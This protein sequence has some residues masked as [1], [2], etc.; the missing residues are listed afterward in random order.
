MTT[1]PRIFLS[2]AHEDQAKVADVYDRLVDAGYRP[3]LDKRDILP[4]EQW[5]LAINKAIRD[6]DFFL[7]CLSA[8]SVGRRG[9]LQREIKTALERWQEMLDEDIYLIP[10]RL[11]EHDVPEALAKLQW[12]D[13]FEPEGW[14]RLLRAIQVGMERRYRQSPS[15]SQRNVPA[16]SDSEVEQELPELRK[17]EDNERRLKAEILRLEAQWRERAGLL[18]PNQE[19]NRK[20]EQLEALQPRIHE[21]RLRRNRYG[22]ALPAGEGVELREGEEEEQRLEVE[23]L[24]L[25]A[26]LRMEKVL[27]TDAP[28]AQES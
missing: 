27:V 21:L 19:L 10:V 6:S 25:E 20:R 23:I 22:R 14:S 9:F 7:V 16:T 11:E 15:T 12:V 3:W 8:R 5:D 1:Q 18:G 4:G 13:L 24:R 26:Q 17:A 2:Y 28:K